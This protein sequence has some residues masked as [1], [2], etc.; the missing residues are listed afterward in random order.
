MKV[1][2]FQNTNLQSKYT[3]FFIFFYKTDLDIT[4]E[5]CKWRI[6]KLELLS[7]ISIRVDLIKVIYKNILNCNLSMLFSATY[8]I[9][10][11]IL[12]Q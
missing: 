9:I 7:L 5:L 1:Y 4:L 8:K 12:T 6:L 11:V 3:I 10:S 2:D